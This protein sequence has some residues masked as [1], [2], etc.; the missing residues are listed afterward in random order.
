MLSTNAVWLTS[1]EEIH[2]SLSPSAGIIDMWH[3]AQLF[4][5]VLGIWTLTLL[6][7]I[8]HFIDWAM[9]G[10]LIL[11]FQDSLLN[12][13][14]HKINFIPLNLI[15]N[16]IGFGAFRVGRWLCF[17]VLGLF[18]QPLP[19]QPNAPKHICSSW[20]V[21]IPTLSLWICPLWTFYIK[22]TTTMSHLPNYLTEEKHQLS[23]T[24]QI[25]GNIFLFCFH[26]LTI[27]NTFKY[28]ALAHCTG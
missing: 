8:K 14:S 18:Q 15:Y 24:Y 5:R 27:I 16:L 2:S 7:C 9:S 28:N 17:L 19:R 6:L 22:R 21:H 10:V 12:Y 3:Q 1:A 11:C 25:H 20:H 26:Y 13:N 4:T 23:L